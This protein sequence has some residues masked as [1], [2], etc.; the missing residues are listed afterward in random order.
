MTIT[1]ALNIKLSHFTATVLHEDGH[2][3]YEEHCEWIFLD[4]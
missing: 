2:V 3:E 4:D 1:R